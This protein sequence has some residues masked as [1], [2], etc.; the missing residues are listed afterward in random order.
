MAP[1]GMHV[2]C[3]GVKPGKGMRVGPAKEF[4]KSAGAGGSHAAA[5]WQGLRTKG[6]KKL[7]K[8]SAGKP[9]DMP[10]SDQAGRKPGQQAAQQPDKGKRVGKRPAVAAR[11]AGGQKKSKK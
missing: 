9:R 5:A 2:L 11:K 1:E 4:G 8:G 3:A 6:Q 7:V 10:A